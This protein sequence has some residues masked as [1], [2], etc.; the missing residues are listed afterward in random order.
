MSSPITP[1]IFLKNYETDVSQYVK[2]V[3]G[4]DYIPGCFAPI[5]FARYLNGFGVEFENNEATGHPYFICEDDTVYLLP[6]LTFEGM[7]VSTPLF[8]PVMGN[9]PKFAAI[10]KPNSR[11]I[12]DA[13]QRAAIKCIAY[14][15]GLG[16]TLWSREGLPDSGLSAEKP[17]GGKSNPTVVSSAP[18]NR[19]AQI[20]SALKESGK[21]PAFAKEFLGTKK[22][23]DL[24]DTEFQELITKIKEG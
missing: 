21:T 13:M 6:Y 12:N 3:Q 16:L 2:S 4:N 9:P 22:A 15:T 14:T 8:F 10:V 24:S 20:Q 7:P 11:D 18:N 5:F 1:E 17:S 19:S 23:A